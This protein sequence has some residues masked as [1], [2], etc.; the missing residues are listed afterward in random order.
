MEGLAD[1][2]M[3]VAGMEL[4]SRQCGQ[5]TPGMHN[6]RPAGHIRPANVLYPALAES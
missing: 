6:P 5:I 4:V 3:G 2:I 1:L